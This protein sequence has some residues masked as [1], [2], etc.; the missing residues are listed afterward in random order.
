MRSK[1][2][3]SEFNL[4]DET[5]NSETQESLNIKTE[6]QSNFSDISYHDSFLGEEDVLSSTF[7]QNEINPVQN[8]SDHYFMMSVLHDCQ[9]LPPRKKLKFKKDVLGLLEKY[10]Y[11]DEKS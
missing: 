10:L 8:K 6:T 11:E 3:T 1:P 2:T 7:K 9:S 5:Q 4:N